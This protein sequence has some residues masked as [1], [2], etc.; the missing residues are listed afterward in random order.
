LGATP[1]V[2]SLDFS[3]AQF[4]PSLGGDPTGNEV[5]AWFQDFRLPGFSGEQRVAVGL[6]PISTDG[7]HRTL[8]Y[9]KA[10]FTSWRLTW[11]FFQEPLESPATGQTVSLTL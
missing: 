9:G 4:I 2:Y 8:F 7:R 1:E 5:F 10:R 11:A 3:G 6:S